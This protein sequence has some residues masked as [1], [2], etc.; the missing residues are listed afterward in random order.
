MILNYELAVIVRK[1]FR[2]K[3]LGNKNNFTYN[4]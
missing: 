4:I 2:K 1:Y 3:I